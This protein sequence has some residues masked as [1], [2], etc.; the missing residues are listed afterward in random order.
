MIGSKLTAWAAALAVILGVAYVT[1]AITAEGDAPDA[2]V[3][4][5]APRGG[6][7]EHDDCWGDSGR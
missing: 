4:G 1:P 7:I 6:G 2:D 5:E 3:V